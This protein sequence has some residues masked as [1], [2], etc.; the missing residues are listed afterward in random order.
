MMSHTRAV[1][2]AVA[3]MIVIVVASNYLV[4]FPVT[5]GALGEFLTWG[6][7]SY[8]VSFLVTD[9]IN[10]FFGPK[11]ARTVVYAG[12]AAGVA[13]SLVFAQFEMTTTRIAIASGLAF[14]SAQLLDVA[15]FNRL[16]AQTWWR[17]PFIASGIASAV[18][19]AL[20]FSIAFYG[21][22]VPW[23]TLALGDFWV[24]MTVAVFMLA[25]FRYAL[26]RAGG[27]ALAAEG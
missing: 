24:K 25:P 13:T 18:D 9:L 14:L 6:A 11:R 10:R 19:T 16:R 5:S 21:T 3:A 23:Q 12:F 26:W 1:G 27:K 7:L 20:F 22:E 2:M 8:P 4:Q 15:I 17:A